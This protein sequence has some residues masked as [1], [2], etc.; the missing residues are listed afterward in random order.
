MLIVN[1]DDWGRSEKET[2][3]ALACFLKGRVTS[4]S[5]M[6]FMADSERAAKLATT[7]NVDAGLH[8]N[9]NENYTGKITSPRAAASHQR[10]LQ[11]MTKSKFAVLI[12]HPFL[13]RHFR[14]VFQ[15]QWEEYVRLFG[16]PPSHVDGHQ[17]RHLSANILLDKII[18]AGVAIRRNFSFW[19]GEK[20]AVNRGYRRCMDSWLARRYRL[21]DYLFNLAQCMHGEK[22]SRFIELARTRAVELE[23]HPVKTVEQTFLNSDSFQRLL[24]PLKLIPYAQ[25]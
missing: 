5:A 18:P 8:L 3:A 11:F 13:R 20:S 4:V 6:V 2:D 16:K 24:Q 12:Y 15:S 14:E 25:L 10:V 9:L 7:H 22:L 17:H 19:P 21:T 1:A 23:T